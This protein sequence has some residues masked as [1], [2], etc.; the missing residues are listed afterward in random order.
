MAY[1]FL[2]DFHAAVLVKIGASMRM[3]MMLPGLLLALSL[4]T[5]FYTF[6]VRVTRSRLGGVLAILIA[7]GAGGMGGWSLSRRDGFWNAI[8]QDTAQNDV[9]GDGKIMW[10]AFIPHVLLPQRG[11][12][13]AYP[14]VMLV[15]TLVWRAGDMRVCER[16]GNAERRAM[17]IM[18]GAFSGSLPLI[19]AHS[20]IALGVMIGVFFALDFHKWT[21]DPRILVSWV[22]AGVVAIAVGYPQMGLF[23]HQVESGHGGHFLNFGWWFKNHDFGRAGGVSGFFNF[24]WMSLGPA[25]PLFIFAVALQ[26]WELFC[27][28]RLATQIKTTA[29]PGKWREFYSLAVYCEP[30][31]PKQPLPPPRYIL[32][33]PTAASG[34]APSVTASGEASGSGVVGAGAGDAVP[35]SYASPA[36]KAARRVTSQPS[37]GAPTPAAGRGLSSRRVASSTSIHSASSSGLESPGAAFDAASAMAPIAPPS[38]PVEVRISS[39]GL[40]YTL[41]SSGGDGPGQRFKLELPSSTASVTHTGL[42]S[43]LAAAVTPRTASAATSRTGSRAGSQGPVVAGAAGGVSARSRGAGAAP[44]PSPIDNEDVDEEGG[45]VDS[46]EDLTDITGIARSAAPPVGA[47]VATAYQASSKGM[48]ASSASNYVLSSYRDPASGAYF[49]EHLWSVAKA[50]A[51]SDLGIDLDVALAPETYRFEAIDRLVFHLNACSLSGRCL[52]TLKLAVGAAAVFLVGNYINFQ[53][54]DRDN[55]KLF[56][57]SVFVNASLVGGLLSAPLEYLWDSFMTKA[58][59]SYQPG[60]ARLASV[61]SLVVPRTYADALFLQS[62]AEAASSSAAGGK[63][64]AASAAGGAGSA[65]A[66]VPANRLASAGSSLPKHLYPEGCDKADAAS[67]KRT[68]GG[69]SGKVALAGSLALV[70]SLLLLCLTGFMMVFREYGLY[71]VL[72]DEDQAAVGDWIIANTP[73]KGVWLHRDVHISPAGEQGSR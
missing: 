31:T 59:A 2:P 27:A 56:Y 22:T 9:S 34:A 52:D 42:L 35:S 62:Q 24:W 36:P 49:S 48:D 18:A 72:L 65:A 73:P 23:K 71:H 10:F 61:A 1:P 64:K 15:L 6:T 28:H 13:F 14:M 44:A 4:V 63:D 26:G 54:W 12:N 58:H 39:L 47:R 40:E 20:F 60:F 41:P 3:A 8:S 11:A 7:I 32:S 51:R 17:L 5:F 53:P 57:V 69:I 29:G 16:I 46:D 43:T 37:S 38:Q 67:L 19:Q 25:V 70:P 21:A 55:C 30:S 50:S 68:A 66:A 45:A 33:P